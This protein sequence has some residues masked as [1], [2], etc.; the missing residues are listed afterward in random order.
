MIILNSILTVFIVVIFHELIHFIIAVI[1]KAKP[2]INFNNFY[3]PTVLYSRKITDLKIIVITSAPIS[4][5]FLLGCIIHAGNY[6]LFLFKIMCL[7]NIVN[8]LPITNDGEIILFSIM[9][10]I[11]KRKL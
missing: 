11:S 6:V 8:L 9:N 4:I 2:S 10:I 7:A 5:L 3:K 1:L